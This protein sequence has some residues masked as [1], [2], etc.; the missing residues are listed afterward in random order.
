MKLEIFVIKNKYN[1]IFSD[2]ESFGECAS[3]TDFKK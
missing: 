1:K 3:I 2:G